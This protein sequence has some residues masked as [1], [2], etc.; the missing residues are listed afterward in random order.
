M[1]ILGIETST[2]SGSVAVIDK[3]QIKGEYYFSIG[4]SHAEKL[5]PS[6]NWLLN[7]IGV[8]KTQLDGVA[9]S[10]GPGSFT[11]L[12]VGV[13]VAKGISYSLGIPVAGFSSLEVLAMNAPFFQ[14]NVCPVIDAKRGEVFCALF[15]SRAGKLER[16]TPDLICNIKNLTE[17]I[18]TKTAFVGEGALLYRDFLEDS[19]GDCRI[20]DSLNLNFPRASMLCVLATHKF[21][22]GYEGDPYKLMPNYIRQSNAEIQKRRSL[23]G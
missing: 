13:S 12:R 23:N 2:Y 17:F 14:C 22:S 20:Y 6:V 5:V 15:N 3:E 4:P 8:E 18:N 10:V 7:D 9:V 21:R 19:L 1:R 16:A 11:S